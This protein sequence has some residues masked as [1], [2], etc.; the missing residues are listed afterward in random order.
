M[1]KILIAALVSLVTACGDSDGRG[2]PMRYAAP[3]EPT[4][5]EESAVTLATSTLSAT[6]A[7][8]TGTD[9]AAAAPGL[10]D[11]LVADL[12]GYA[13]AKTMPTVES[14][15]LAA[16]TTSRAID[17]GGIDPLCV[18]TSASGS[19]TLVTWSGCTDTLTEYDPYTQAP[20]LTATV[21]VNG[22]M[23]WNVSTGVTSWDLALGMD[24][25]GTQ[26]GEPISMD[27]TVDLT[28]SITTTPTTI[29]GDTRSVT[30]LAMTYAGQSASGS[31]ETKLAL[32]LDLADSSCVTGITGGT[33][34]LEQN[35][36]ARPAG[37]TAQDYPNQGWRFEWTGCGAFTVAHGS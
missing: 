2:V 18:Q 22:T 1:K 26:N 9:P 23:R 13:A 19:E 29:V 20:T 3:A 12:G 30:S 11:Q 14:A 16:R 35:W 32:D 6:A 36:L 34:V 15:K 21:T 28:G 33:L 27:L 5:S 37:G 24:M 10:G 8:E 17:T 31:Y 25:S 7:F 4:W